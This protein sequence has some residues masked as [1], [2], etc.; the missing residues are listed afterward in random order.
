M[1]YQTKEGNNI[2]M[3]ITNIPAYSYF[4]GDTRNY[5]TDMCLLSD[6]AL[7]ESL[8][9]RYPSLTSGQVT[10]FTYN[11]DPIKYDAYKKI[12]SEVGGNIIPYLG[13]QYHAAYN[14]NYMPSAT[15]YSWDNMM[16]ALN[17]FGI[18]A[19]FF[20]VSDNVDITAGGYVRP[21]KVVCLNNDQLGGVYIGRITSS[22]KIG[23]NGYSTAA[24]AITIAVGTTEVNCTLDEVIF[25]DGI[26][27]DEGLAPAEE[28]K[29]GL[30]IVTT[31]TYRVGADP[32]ITN[33]RCTAEGWTAE[34]LRSMLSETY[35]NF[36][37]AL[38]GMFTDDDSDKDDPYSDNGSSKEGGGDGAGGG[39]WIDSIDGAQIPP[40]PNINVCDLGLITM[41]NPTQAQVKAL[42]DFLWSG[43]FDLNTYKKLFSEPMEG[44][45]GLAI[46]P[47]APDLAG[48]KTVKIGNIDTN[49]NMSYLAS[50]WKEVDCGWVDIEKFVG[51]FMDADPY[52]KIS[53]YLPFIGIRSLSAD[54]ING[55]SIHVVYHVDVLTGACACFI[56][57]SSRGVLYTYNGSC[58]T[59][60]PLTAVNFSG[61][62]QN[63]VSAVISG[64][65]MV[66]GMATGAAPVTAMSAAGLLNS[67]ANTALNSKPHIQR[68]G[69]LG[70]SAGILSIL[71]PYV[72]IERPDISMPA[73]MNKHIGNT[74]NMTF[75]L[76]AISGFTMCEYVHIEG[77]TGTSEEIKEIEALLKEGV[78]L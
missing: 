4:T 29:Y 57:H 47:V 55:G 37:P 75:T 60:V 24:Y 56:E 59:N 26:F 52:T 9:N 11:G 2:N 65:G 61:A 44:L 40:L 8:I 45:I 51:C 6:T 10:L 54:D 50:N 73:Q 3:K 48:A 23:F 38:S 14:S 58:I 74:L 43:L 77:C 71:T 17:S 33:M 1:N 22:N 12:N 20:Q 28:G 18:K 5:R 66:G 62:I 67:A 63:A 69:N 32:G 72:I 7:I 19:N 53:I 42:S 34:A 46:V 39:G 16:R 70:G 25:R 27:N 78:Y 35:A 68:S 15:N 13:V 36:D 64:I 21:S 30:K 41:Y 76:G 31:F 49:V